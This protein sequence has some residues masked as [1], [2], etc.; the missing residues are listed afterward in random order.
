MLF[1]KDGQIILNEAK[2]TLLDSHAL[3]KGGTDELTDDLTS[4]LVSYKRHQF[5]HTALIRR[6]NVKADDKFET[7]KPTLDDIMI[8]YSKENNNA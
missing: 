7:E 1:I 5:G 4:R 8:Y 6:E 2:D 3:I